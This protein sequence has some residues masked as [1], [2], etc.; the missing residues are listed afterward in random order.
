MIL[1]YVLTIRG[2]KLP[3]W[4]KLRSM[5]EPLQWVS[6]VLRCRRWFILNAL[7]RAYI[8]TRRM[9]YSSRGKYGLYFYNLCFKLNCVGHRQIYVSSVHE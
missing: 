5:F 1:K 8:A 6:R 3:F 9:S 4:K 2:K 7:D